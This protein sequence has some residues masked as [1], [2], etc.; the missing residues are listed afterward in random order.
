[1]YLLGRWHR[2]LF[3][4]AASRWENL[5][6]GTAGAFGNTTVYLGLVR[7]LQDII[8]HKERSIV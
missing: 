6:E 5:R 1:M 7:V 2:V 8:T 4:R 3:G